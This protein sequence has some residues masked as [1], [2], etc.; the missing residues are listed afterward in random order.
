MAMGDTNTLLIVEPNPEVADA[1]A[2]HFEDLG[3]EVAKSRDGLDAVMQI[4]QE[5][6]RVVVM[7]LTTPRL[8]GVDGLRLL[9][10]CHSDLSIVLADSERLPCRATDGREPA[11]G[12][13]GEWWA[14]DRLVATA[15][16]QPRTGASASRAADSLAHAPAAPAVGRARILVVDDLEDVRELLRDVLEAEGYDVELAGDA[17]TAISKLVEVRPQVILLDISLPGLSGI[18]AL[19]QIRARDPKIGVIMVT[20]NGDQNIARRTLALGAFDYIAKPIDFD[21]LRRSIETLLAMRALVPAESET[22][23]LRQAV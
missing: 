14:L 18:S 19:Q 10:R 11:G 21:Y 17:N 6:P 13:D 22:E 9:R 3:Y 5:P 1:M 12:A 7:G 2:A 4:K 23:G 16:A 15:T 8:G 20:G